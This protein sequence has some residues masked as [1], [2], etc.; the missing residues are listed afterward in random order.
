M[1]RAATPIARTAAPTTA[2][3]QGRVTASSPHPAIPRIARTR[4]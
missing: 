1:A 3:S 4:G 2:D